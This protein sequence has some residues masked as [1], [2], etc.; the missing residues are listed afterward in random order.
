MT[1]ASRP[2]SRGVSS[3]RACSAVPTVRM[4]RS[5]AAASGT[6]QQT[7]ASTAI[8][9]STVRPWRSRVSVSVGGRSKTC[10]R[11]SIALDRVDRP[12]QLDVQPGVVAPSWVTVGS[13]NRVT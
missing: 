9:L 7:K 1:A 6:R 12:G 8:V 11:R 3:R 13:P 4:N 5:A 10:S 2:V